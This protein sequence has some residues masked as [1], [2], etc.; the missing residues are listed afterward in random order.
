MTQQ[1]LKGFFSLSHIKYLQNI[2]VYE[3]LVTA[4]YVSN[5]A[6]FYLKFKQDEY[7]YLYFSI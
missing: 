7:I 6:A 4:G 1:T 3:K 5:K 2:L